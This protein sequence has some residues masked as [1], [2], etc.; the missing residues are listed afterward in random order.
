FAALHTSDAAIEMMYGECLVREELG[1]SPTL[2]EYLQR[3][4][5]YAD[6]LAPPQAI[7]GSSSG[8]TKAAG[9][10]TGRKRSGTI[11]SVPGF[12]ILEELGGGGM[13]VV[14]KARQLAPGRAV[15]LKVI[16]SEKLDAPDMLR[17]F[18][19]EMQ[20]AARLAH[21]NIVEVYEASQVGDLH[22]I[23]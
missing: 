1:E 10:E 13:G 23:V 5:Q 9:S 17:R 8:R 2:E 11:P 12:E 6:S 20:V 3:F 22:Y 15:A 14:Y 4:P 21:A 19:R 16:R 7:T 18:Q